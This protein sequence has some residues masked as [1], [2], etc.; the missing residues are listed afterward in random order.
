MSI[1][2]ENP[3]PFPAANALRLVL[4]DDPSAE[5]GTALSGLV[6]EVLVFA[7]QL[8]FATREAVESYLAAKW[9]TAEPAHDMTSVA[10]AALWLDASDEDSFTTQADGVRFWDSRVGDFRVE[11]AAPNTRP[12]RMSDGLNGL[13]VVRFDGVDDVMVSAN[14]KLV[15]DTGYTVAV[16]FRREAGTNGPVF[17]G[18]DADNRPGVMLQAE[19]GP[20]RFRFTHRSPPAFSGGNFVGVADASMSEP[21][22]AVVAVDDTHV[23][24]DTMSASGTSEAASR[25]LDVPALDQLLTYCVGGSRPAD[26][27]DNFSGDVAEIVVF[28]GELNTAQREYVAAALDAKWG[29]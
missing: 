24:L 25:M 10:N 17:F 2:A 26:E 27:I 1:P 20:E 28:Y 5:D 11:A 13:P 9:E 12:T 8:D 21:M 19:T 3:E 29:F 7:S 15:D 14:I 16:V 22:R 4:G 18:V 23:R 6:G